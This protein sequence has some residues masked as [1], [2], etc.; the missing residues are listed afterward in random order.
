LFQLTT[1][2][3]KLVDDVVYEVEGAK[4]VIKPGE[5]DIG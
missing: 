5:V 3:R 2:C 1:L 4:V